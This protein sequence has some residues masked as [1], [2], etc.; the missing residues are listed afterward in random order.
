MSAQGAAPR[1]RTRGQRL[2]NGEP[3]NSTPFPATL[4]PALIERLAGHGIRSLEDWLQLGRKRHQLFG[5][6]PSMVAKLDEL[7]LAPK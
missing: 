3:A 1:G 7:A 4:A 2:I 6:V 5:I